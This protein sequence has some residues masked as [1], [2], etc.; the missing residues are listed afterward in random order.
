VI[1]GA[2]I[3]TAVV[4]YGLAG[5]VF[6]AP[7]VAAVDGLDLAYVVTGNEARADRARRRHPTVRVLPDLDALLERRA[8]IDL[9]VVA[10]P[11][12]SHVPVALAAI[13]AGL[14]VVV[15]K[16]V[17]VTTAEVH[18]LRDAAAAAGALI[19]VYHNR[20]W[21]ADALTVRRLLADGAL[22][23]VHRFES[24]YE[25]WL[26]EVDANAWR[27]Q[28]DEE[29]AGGLLYDLGS[30]LVDQALDFFGPVDAVYA[31]VA[32]RRPGARVDDDFFVALRHRGGTTSHLWASVLAADHGPRFRVLGSTAA[33]VKHGMDVQE[34]ALGRGGSPRDAGWG[35]EP[36]AAWGVLG[37]PA[38]RTTV[39]SEPGAYQAYYVAVRDALRGVGP[40]PVTIDQAA[41]VI[42]VIEAARQSARDGRVVVM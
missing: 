42:A 29:A 15:D 3:R 17:A 27:E 14:A 31:E 5:S 6:H 38:Q 21:D 9:V 34:D 40:L 7:L 4:G 10:T 28:P 24:R 19:S 20:R 33:Y 11:N 8:D 36:E 32:A 26:P 22:G 16:P 23:R 12:A 35:V 41:Q 2:D 13:A 39:P 25:R 30:H 37:T 1:E 18:R